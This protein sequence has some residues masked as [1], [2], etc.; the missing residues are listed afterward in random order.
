M[1]VGTNTGLGCQPPAQSKIYKF[2]LPQNLTTYSLLLTGRL[3][4]NGWLTR[5]LY[6]YYIL[7]SYNKITQRKGIKKTV[8]ENTLTVLYWIKKISYKRIHIVQSYIQE[9]TVFHCISSLKDVKNKKVE[10]AKRTVKGRVNV[11]KEAWEARI[12]KECTGNKLILPWQE[13]RV[14]K[15][16]LGLLRSL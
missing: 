4:N 7:H 16:R 8:R 2:L 11:M 6:V 9:S 5:T 15:G 14:W 12:I 1:I 10:K 13:S 3:S